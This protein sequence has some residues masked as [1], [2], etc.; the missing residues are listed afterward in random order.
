MAGGA[1]KFGHVHEASDGRGFKLASDFVHIHDLQATIL[2]LLGFDHTK[3]TYRSQ[4]RDFRLT[5]IHS[6]VVKQILA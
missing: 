2:S 3:L 6:L 5:N 4:V 1:E